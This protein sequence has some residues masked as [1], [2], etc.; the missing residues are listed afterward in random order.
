MHSFRI[1]M[2]AA[3]AMT[4]L[5]VWWIRRPA[6]KRRIPFTRIESNPDLGCR[7]GS[8]VG[9]SKAGELRAISAAELRLLAGRDGNFI[10]VD[11]APD[12]LLTFAGH[13]GTFVI[14]IAPGELPAVLR[15][16]PADRAVVFRGVSESARALIEQS[17]CMDSSKPRCV[18]SDLPVAL[19]VL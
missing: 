8:S 2:L 13:A 5:C 7:Q 17:A 10:L 3:A 18:L 15:W 11:V 14:S 1:L 12:S 4:S 6:A 9:G 19:E 16:L